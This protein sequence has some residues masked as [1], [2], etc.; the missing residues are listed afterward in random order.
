MA[1][2]EQTRK[3]ITVGWGARWWSA[4]IRN[5]WGQQPGP[6]GWWSTICEQLSRDRASTEASF[7]MKA[8]ACAGCG[9]GFLLGWPIHPNHTLIA[10]LP[11][12][13]WTK[14]L[15][16]ACHPPGEAPVV[17]LSQEQTLMGFPLWLRPRDPAT[18]QEDLKSLLQ[19]AWTADLH[20]CYQICKILWPI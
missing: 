7:P 11:P 17:L 20:L 16:P 1:F 4:T 19:A 5:V 2:G 12:Y 9:R 10:F 6:P 3:R 18:K 14:P 15:C 13:Y 8:P